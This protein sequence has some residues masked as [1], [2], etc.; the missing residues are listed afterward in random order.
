MTAD[1]ER[2]HSPSCCHCVAR[3]K[4]WSWG[5]PHSPPAPGVPR[6]GTEARAGSHSPSGERQCHSH[7]Q[8]ETPRSPMGHGG[9][10]GRVRGGEN[11]EEEIS[12]EEEIGGGE[13]MFLTISKCTPGSKTGKCGLGVGRAGRAGRG[14]GREQPLPPAETP[15]RPPAA[16]V[17]GNQELLTPAQSAAHPGGTGTRHFC[18]VPPSSICSAGLRQVTAL[19]GQGD[20]TQ[21][22]GKPRD[23]A[24]GSGRPAWQRLSPVRQSVL[25][26]WLRRSMHHAG[27]SLGLAVDGQRETGTRRP[28][29]WDPFPEPPALGASASPCAVHT[30][31]GSRHSPAWARVMAEP[32]SLTKN[33][34]RGKSTGCCSWHIPSAPPGDT[35][36]TAPHCW[37]SPPP[38]PSSCGFSL[39]LP[40]G[41]RDMTPGAGAPRSVLSPVPSH[42]ATAS[43]KALP[44]P[45]PDRHKQTPGKPGWRRQEVLPTDKT[46]KAVKQRTGFAPHLAPLPAGSRGWQPYGSS[47]ALGLGARQHGNRQRW[48]PSCRRIFKSNVPCKS[49]G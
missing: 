49:S 10:P 5:T 12:G 18:P 17:P 27:A 16:S 29:G 47:R 33:M 8:P 46:N 13:R 15:S 48:K 41:H 37:L 43:H 1:T 40:R 34:S 6:V 25:C 45:L 2:Q 32:S 22:P 20:N 44:P 38:G 24:P 21:F 9:R 4:T 19:P 3:L 26:Q 39:S 30:G 31:P 36:V 42:G 28:W 23:G 14:R 35:T 7:R 11:G